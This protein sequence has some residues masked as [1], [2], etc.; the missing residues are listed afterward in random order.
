VGRAHGTRALDPELI[1]YATELRKRAERRLGE[2]MAAQPKSKGQGQRGDDGQFHQ[3]VF[4]KPAGDPATLV[5]AGIDKNLAHRARKAA[6][7]T[8]TQFE[9]DLADAKLKASGQA[10]A[11]EK[12]ARR[13]ANPKS[14]SRVPRLRPASQNPELIEYATELRKRPERRLGEMMAAQPK[15]K[16]TQSQLIG[17]GIIG[18]RSAVLTGSMLGRSGRLPSFTLPARRCPSWPRNTA[19]ASAR[20]GG[21]FNPTAKK[22]H[23]SRS[24]PA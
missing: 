1:E 24:R 11:Q 12:G 7:M 9:K 6:K 3:R 19:S 16:G 14:G 17:R 4:E 13:Q 15:A 23:K 22:R 21:H 8:E 10:Q 5:D 20:S 18:P 2:M